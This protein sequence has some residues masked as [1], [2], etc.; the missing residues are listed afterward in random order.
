MQGDPNPRPVRVAIKIDRHGLSR[1][2]AMWPSRTSWRIGDSGSARLEAHMLN[3]GSLWLVAAEIPSD[4]K[5]TKEIMVTIPPEVV[6]HLLRVINPKNP[7]H[8]AALAQAIALL[9]EAHHAFMT[10]ADQVLK[11]QDIKL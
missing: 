8:G 7:E 5:G 11:D 10:A 2:E 6:A 3:D 9:A 4:D 1:L